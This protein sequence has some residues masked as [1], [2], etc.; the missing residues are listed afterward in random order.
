MHKLLL[1]LLLTIN[2][3]AE[4]YKNK[5][6]FGLVSTFYNYTEKDEQGK[7]LDTE[8]SSVLD[9]GGFYLSYDHKLKDIITDDNTKI[10]HYINIYSS[11]E[12]GNTQ[13]TGSTLTEGD[14]CDIFGCFTS[15]TFNTFFDIQVNLKRVHFYERSSTYIA[16]GLGYNEW[17]R[18]LSTTQIEIY[19]YNYAQ[20][21][22]GGEKVIFQNYSLGLDLSAQLGFKTQMDANFAATENTN[23]IN[24]TF[25]LGAVYSY[26]V[27]V[28][29][30]IPITNSL[31]LK[32][33]A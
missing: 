17:K 32:A 23:S 26:T 20:I 30:I 3:Y 25:D 31:A 29:L 24:E 33:K 6:D 27:A 19:K 7:V 28:P 1:I 2:I 21:S 14:G 18:E 8:V 11:L 4:V 12:L 16:F 15:N 5:L 10:A 9:L 22:F 13:Y